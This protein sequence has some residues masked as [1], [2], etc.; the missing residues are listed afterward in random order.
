MAPS[1]PKQSRAIRTRKNLMA[2]L[3][4]LLREKEFETISVQDIA[5]AAG[6][7]VGSVYAHF[8]DKTAFLEALLAYWRG[9]V[10]AQLQA[11]E[12][13]DMKAAFQALG[14]LRAALLETTKAVY[15]QTLENGH[16]FRA[17]QTY[18]RLH[19]D[20]D[21]QDWQTLVVR[22]FAPIADLLEV[23]SDEITVKDVDLATRMLG[24][25]FNTIFIR[26]ALMPQDTLG[27]AARLD[28]E[29]MIAEVS[30][31]AY[32]YLTVPR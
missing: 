2:A 1:A 13:Q 6:V 4:R 9:R 28:A 19:P 5:K 30:D 18:V 22:S 20:T 29:T 11:A 17:L 31:M 7:A 15:A 14:S 12:A 23:F 3:E 8:K 27:Q 25:F 16:I 32:G 24:V 21:D 26:N 10:E